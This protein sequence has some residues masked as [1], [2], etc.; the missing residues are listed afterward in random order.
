MKKLFTLGFYALLTGAL[1]LGCKKDD[2]DP[3]DG[4]GLNL[5]VFSLEDDRKLG[6]QMEQYIRDSTDYVILDSVQYSAAYIYMNKIKNQILNSPSIKHKNDFKWK[7]YIIK[8]DSTLNAFATPG[9]YIYVY[10]GLMKYLE[11]DDHFMGVMGHEI[12]HADQRHSTEQMTKQY[13]LQTLYDII[14]GKNQGMLSEVTKGVI[15]LKFSREAE[16][17]AD[18]FSVRYLCG[19]PETEADGAAG[20]FQKLLDKGQT[21]GTPE[22]LST[23]PS[24]A[25]RVQDISTLAEQLKCNTTPSCSSE[26]AN[27]VASLPK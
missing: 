20:F 26:Y 21:G 16:S 23:H 15:G 12:A 5:N 6:A 8:D 17:E 9:G 4:G 24:P 11:C 1:L 27:I 22:F 18:E 14:L 25:N 10:T 7:L 2:E 19:I 3:G 13:G